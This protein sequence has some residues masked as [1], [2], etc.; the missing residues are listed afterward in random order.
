MH[1]RPRG[2]T[3]RENQAAPDE[4]L[5]DPAFPHDPNP[6]ASGPDSLE[7]GKAL[8]TRIK[9]YLVDVHQQIT[10]QR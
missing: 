1:Y 9:E 6:P 7:E 8:R 4:D 10:A 5:H 2:T 3:A